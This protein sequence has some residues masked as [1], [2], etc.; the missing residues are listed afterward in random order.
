MEYFER[1]YDYIQCILLFLGIAHDH[2]GEIVISISI[3]TRY[4]CHVDDKRDETC[5]PYFQN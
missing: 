3:M 1:N 5:V 4:A 2:K